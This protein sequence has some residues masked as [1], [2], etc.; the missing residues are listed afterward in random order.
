MTSFI[1]LTILNIISFL[2]LSNIEYNNKTF[3]LVKKYYYIEDTCEFCPKVTDNY[4]YTIEKVNDFLKSNPSTI[5][6]SFIV[7]KQNSLNYH[8]TSE[9]VCRSLFDSES[10]IKEKKY[11]SDILSRTFLFYEVYKS[12]FIIKTKVVLE[13]IDNNEHTFVS[14]VKTK[15][16]EDIC[17]FNTADNWGEKVI[18]SEKPPKIGDVLYNITGI[19]GVR[20]KNGFVIFTGIYFGE[21]NNHTFLSSIYAKPGSSGSPVFN[22]KGKLVGAIHTTYEGL[23]NISM[24]TKLKEIQKI[25][26]EIK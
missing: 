6:S 17:I 16:E 11:I 5:A 12:N 24:S 23:K 8:I 13:D 1:Y 25:L 21:K 3:S 20:S 26:E 10:E 7:K 2:Q 18:F 9:H 19:L 14:V 22:L 15:R 4:S